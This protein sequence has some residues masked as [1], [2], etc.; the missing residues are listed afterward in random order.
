MYVTIYLLLI[1]CKG[2]SERL[3][4]S[5]VHFVGVTTMC[6]TQRYSPE[7]PGCHSLKSTEL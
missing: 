5:R 4:P 6:P 3:F 7:F 1:M 2:T